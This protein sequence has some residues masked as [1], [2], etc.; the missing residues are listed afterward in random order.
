MFR[1]IFGFVSNGLGILSDHL[2]QKRAIKRAETEGRIAIE[3]IKVAAAEERKTAG[4]LH[5]IKWESTMAEA[6]K[7]SWK[8]EWFAV[9]LSLPFL[10]SMFGFSDMAD[11]AFE[12]MSKAPEWYTAAFLVA[13][14]ASFGVRLWKTVKKP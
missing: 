12:A 6:S 11:S 2:E 4:D 8:D 7:G 13:V 9:I 14:G 10:L 5:D 1:A 3:R